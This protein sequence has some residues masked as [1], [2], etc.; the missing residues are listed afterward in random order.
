MRK[1]L[2]AVFTLLLATC[3]FPQQPAQA[4]ERKIRF[5]VMKIGALSNA[6]LAQEQ[7]FFKKHGVDVELVTIRS[8]AEGITAVQGGSID[9]TLAIPSFAFSANERKFDLV[10]VMQNELAS[11]APPD[12]GGIV[13][14]KDSKIQKLSD[15]VG[16]TVAVN[17]LHAQEAVDAQYLIRKAGVPKDK[18]K[19]VEVPFPS[20]WDVLSKKQ[21][22]A[23]VAVDPFTTMMRQRGGRV[24]AWEYVDSIAGQPIGTFWA[25]RAW[26]EK[27]ADLLERFTAAMEESMAFMNAD[28][29]RAR[30]VVA[31]YTRLPADLVAAMPP[32]VWS[33]KIDLAKWREL[34]ELLRS[35]DELK[36]T[37]RP[38]DI[39]SSGV[40]RRLGIQG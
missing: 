28:P 12:T 24:I 36:T 2:L 14:A 37:P 25:K 22:D 5:G 38:E 7:G 18:I 27:N 13:V 8:G 19:Y 9:V 20:M 1:A 29:A 16:G 4:Q 26:A 35:M 11:M 10:L 32:I 15:L 30:S 40:K 6:W 33:S 17:S 3:L 21:A 31:E 23:A 39:F 34:V